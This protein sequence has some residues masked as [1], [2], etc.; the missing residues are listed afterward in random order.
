[1]ATTPRCP[2]CGQP[3]QWEGNPDRPF[4][5]ERCRVVDLGSWAD[6]RYRVSDEP[7]NQR[8]AEKVELGNSPRVREVPEASDQ[9]ISDETSDGGENGHSG[10]NRE[11]RE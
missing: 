1:M 3:V 5:S 9:P 11:P 7:R 10:K 8:G 6:E 4:C 2:T